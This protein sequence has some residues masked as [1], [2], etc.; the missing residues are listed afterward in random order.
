MQLF[1]KLSEKIKEMVDLLRYP[2]QPVPVPVKTGDR[3]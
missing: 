1:S 2:P 3:K